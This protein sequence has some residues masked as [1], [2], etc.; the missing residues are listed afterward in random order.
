MEMNKLSKIIDK[1][2]LSEKKKEYNQIIN[3]LDSRLSISV[4]L[5]SNDNEH[6]NNIH[7]HTLN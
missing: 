3:Q 5:F 7:T 4:P 2:K 6:L 1:K